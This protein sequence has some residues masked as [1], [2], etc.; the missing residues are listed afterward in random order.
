MGAP[1]PPELATGTAQCIPAGCVSWCL[2]GGTPLVILEIVENAED[3]A[4]LMP[5]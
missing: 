3:A 2:I 5:F 4:G 1:C